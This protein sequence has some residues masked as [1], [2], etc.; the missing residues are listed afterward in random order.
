MS[1]ETGG[2]RERKKRQ[3]YQAISDAAIALFLARGFDRVSVAE[4]AA[5]AGI[6]KPT[7]FRYFPAKEDLVLHRLAD[8][9]DEPARVVAARPPGTSP[10]D[11]L[12]AHFLAGLDR[13]DPV[14]GVNDEPEV[15][16]LHRLLY[17]TPGLVARLYAFQGRSERALAEALGGG[18]VRE[19]L[20][21]GQIVAVLRILA[22]EN[23]RRIASGRSADQVRPGA[24]DAA[25]LAFGQLR[26]GLERREF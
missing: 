22:E 4:I 23:A 2:L 18:G 1:G 25:R 14:T 16:A 10:L 21:A 24:A 7:L 5:A 17:G 19:R 8:H 11:A 6:S 9:E 3:T 26:D 12:L 15:L 13:H 20:A